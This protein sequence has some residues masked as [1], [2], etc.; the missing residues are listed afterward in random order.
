[1]SGSSVSAEGRFRNDRNCLALVGELLAHLQA[2]GL[3]LRCTSA[4]LARV[5]RAPDRAWLDLRGVRVLNVELT[6]PG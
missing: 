2:P 6:Q 4:G 5:V 3:V 1:M